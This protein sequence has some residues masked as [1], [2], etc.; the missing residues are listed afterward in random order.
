ME[1]KQFIL[2]LD[3][4]SAGAC[5]C[6]WA[7]VGGHYLYMRLVVVDSCTPSIVIT[8]IDIHRKVEELVLLLIQ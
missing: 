5:C 7:R 3:R 8:M 1:K 6:Q 2:I 4:D